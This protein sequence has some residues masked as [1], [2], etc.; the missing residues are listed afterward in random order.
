MRRARLHYAA[1][2]LDTAK[3]CGVQ[4]LELS[5]MEAGNKRVSD[6]VIDYY[7]SV[8]RMDGHEARALRDQGEGS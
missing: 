4:S 6:P 7:A 3:G 2:L 8:F 5:A 1:K